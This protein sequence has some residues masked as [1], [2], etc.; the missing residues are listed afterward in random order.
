MLYALSR[1][2]TAEARRLAEGALAD[3]S[4]PVAWAVPGVFQAGQGWAALLFGDTVSGLASS[5]R[6]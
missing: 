1:G 5:S 2:R 3:T 4:P 6:V